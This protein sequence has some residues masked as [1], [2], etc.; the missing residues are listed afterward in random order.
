MLGFIGIFQ[1]FGGIQV[2]ELGSL[3]RGEQVT[4]AAE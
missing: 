2:V 1:I 3:L 4:N